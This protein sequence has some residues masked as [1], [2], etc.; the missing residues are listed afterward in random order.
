MT[1][2]IP[3]ENHNSKR[4]TQPSVHCSTIYSI[5][6]QKQ[7]KYPLTEEW[8]KK[9][10]YIYRMEYYSAV[11]KNKTICSNLDG[12]RH[13]HTE[14]S[15]TQKDKHHVISLICGSTKKQEG[16]KYLQTRSRVIDIENKF[17]VTWRK[18]D[19]FGD[20]D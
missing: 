5:H 16:Y 20:W 18:G 11:K 9:L 13:C 14:G 17:L 8:I 3:R 1:Q 2:N 12:P 19:T 10:W 4:Y 15:Q 7:P 6:T